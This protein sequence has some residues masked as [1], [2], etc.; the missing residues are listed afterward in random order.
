MKCLCATL[1][2]SSR[3]LTRHYEKELQQAG[4][5]PAQFEL[6]GTL[7]AQSEI[8]QADLAEALGLDQTTLSRNLKVLIG[9][10]WVKAAASAKDHRRA[11]YTLSPEGRNVWTRALPYWQRA[12]S[13][14]QEALGKDW[15]AI[16]SALDRLTSA[17][18]SGSSGP[19]G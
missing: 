8:L 4:L 13:Q 17:T 3:L 7:S 9:R 12:H 6:L 15:S 18:P 5:T 19:L 16:W 10:R 1:R 14:M 2:R 11:V